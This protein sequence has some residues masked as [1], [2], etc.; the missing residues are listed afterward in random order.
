MKENYDKT[1][2]LACDV[3]FLTFNL[4]LP[5][6]KLVTKFGYLDLYLFSYTLQDST[7]DLGF[8]VYKPGEECPDLLFQSNCDFFY[9]IST[10]F[11][12]SGLLYTLTTIFLLTTIITSITSSRPKFLQSGLLDFFYPFSN[13]ALFSIL[14]FYSKTFESEIIGVK[15]RFDTQY[16]L[17]GYLLWVN[18]V[19][20]LASSYLSSR[21]VPSQSSEK[22]I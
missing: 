5:F 1:I 7:Q 9:R 15:G 3:L 14:V 10:G 8:P 13:L 4:I 16:C 21:L 2:K 18:I 11:Y 12:L 6:I 19:I 22:L 17:G 20:S